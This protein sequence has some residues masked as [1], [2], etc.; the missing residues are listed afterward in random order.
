VEQKIVI[1]GDS[2][3]RNGAAELQHS[4]GSTFAVSSFVK[5]GAG[6]ELIVDTLK[7]DIIKL[8]SDD[9][10]V[11]WGG[12]NDI[13]KNNTQEALKH[14]CNFVKNNQRVN[15][16]VMTVPPR[17]DLLSSCVNYEV[18]SF[19]RQLKKR[20]IL[21][22]N[23]KILE[24]DP[25]G[26]YFIKQGLHLNSSGKEYIALRL[27]TVVKS[28]FNKERMSLICLQWKDDTV[29]SNQDRNNNDSHV[30]S[31]NEVTV[32]QS[33][34]SKSPKKT[35]GKELQE[36]PA[37]MNK[38]NENEVKTAHPQ[39]ARRREKTSIERPGFFMDNIKPAF[40]VSQFIKDNELVNLTNTHY[41][42]NETGCV[43]N[44][45]EYE[46]IL[47]HNVQ[48]LNN[49]LLDI[50]IMLTTENL[51]V[52]I[53]CS[54]EHWLSEVQM[55]V[56]NIDYFR[57]VSNFSRNHSISGGSCIFTI[58]N[59]NLFCVHLIHRGYDPSDMELVNTE[60]KVTNIIHD[61]RYNTL[62][63]R[64]QLSRHILTMAYNVYLK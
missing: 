24:T 62:N 28:F 13:G 55:N 17:C 58:F 63:F 25:D 39:L 20:M 53:L 30:T 5:P 46:I 8:R 12:S 64:I 36:S 61:V 60:N 10:V 29:I 6:I 48:S 21:Y 2:H 50:A 16:V 19:N 9:V 43:M 35:L 15:I 33:Q 47:H 23:V 3:A 4:L 40:T 31:C 54:T 59:F 14:L 32:P 56:L 18:I 52:N 49:K 45:N 34:P 41:L 51:N 11:V 57:L 42:C 1:I 22:S 44:F 7:E 37:S 27:A 38:I 26:E